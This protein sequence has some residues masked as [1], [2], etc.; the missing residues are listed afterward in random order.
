MLLPGQQV[1]TLTIPST[2]VSFP[3]ISPSTCSLDFTFLFFL[4]FFTILTPAPYFVT[5][6]STSNKILTLALKYAKDSS[7]KSNRAWL[8]HRLPQQLYYLPPLHLQLLQNVFAPTA[9]TASPLTACLNH[10][11]LVL[12]FSTPLAEVASYIH[13]VK[14]SAHCPGLILHEPLASFRA[15]G[16]WLPFEPPCLPLPSMA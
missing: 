4:Q 12:L 14:S 8:S 15:V 7:I 2:D 11:H 3:T 10:F 13:E 16:H 1:S 5:S 9:S 6:V